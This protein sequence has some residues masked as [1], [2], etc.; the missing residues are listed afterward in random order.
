MHKLNT[1]SILL[2]MFFLF[3]PNPPDPLPLLLPPD[4]GDIV[5]FYIQE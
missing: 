5:L 3:N 1:S 2:P 4:C